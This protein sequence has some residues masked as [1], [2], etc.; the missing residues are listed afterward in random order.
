M[1]RAT[2]L[3]PAERIKYWNIAVGDTVRVITGPSKGKVGK[4]QEIQPDRNR[5]IVSGVNVV[6]KVLPLFLAQKSGLENQRFE[7]A[8]PIHY[9]NV[10]LVGEIPHNA[11]DPRADGPKRTVFVKRVDRGKLFFNKERKL[12]TW[13]RWIP[14]E[15]LFL[16][17]PRAGVAERNTREHE[18][19]DTPEAALKSQTYLETL[20]S[21]PVPETVMDELRNRYSKL[22]W[23]KI[24]TPRWVARHTPEGVSAE[25]AESEAVVGED[26]FEVAESADKSMPTPREPQVTV[27]QLR[28]MSDETISTLAKAMQARQR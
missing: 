22:G 21:P 16:P 20:H 10:Q 18:G 11:L 6:K 4:V 25:A 8:S 26:A 14:G 2:K 23:Q 13:R 15:G 27:D 12:L 9:S 28:G 5:L 3:K 24:G 7:F 19:I 1:D 17:W